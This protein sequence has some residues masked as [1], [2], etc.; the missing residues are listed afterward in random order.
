M[1]R[2]GEIGE[3]AD[4]LQPQMAI[5]CDI[6]NAHRESFSSLEDIARE[7]A[8]LAG[9]V[10][11]SGKVILDCDSEWYSLMRS[12]TR[13]RIVTTSFGSEADYAGQPI[14]DGVLRVNG[15][16]YTMPL[17]GEHIMRNALRAIA[18]GLELGLRPDRI[19]EGLRRFEAAPMRWQEVEIRSVSF[20]NDAYNA[21]PL[22]MRAGL[23]TL[24]GLS[25]GGAKWAVIGGMRELGDVEAEEHAALGRFIDDLDLDGVV[26]VGGLAGMISCERVESFFQCGD[27][28][29]AAEVLKENLKAGDHV[30]VKA[31]R[32][33]R[34]EQVLELFREM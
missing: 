16:D 25:A 13:A 22:S 18:L 23:R 7:K 14:T 9:Q 12:V 4:L 31:S 1:N 8:A 19:A 29:A 24:A 11:P 10:P 34:L 17:P 27:A 2:P 33:E 6:C 32:G 28:A 20:I 3:L 26:A 30:L 21:N 5:L 15:Y